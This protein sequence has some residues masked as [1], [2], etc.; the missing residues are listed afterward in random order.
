MRMVDQV[1]IQGAHMGGATADNYDPRLET[2]RILL[3]G[4]ENG[5]QE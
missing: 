3:L 4:L 5:W 2:I 1:F